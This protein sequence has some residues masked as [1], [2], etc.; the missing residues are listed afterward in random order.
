MWLRRSVVRTHSTVPFNFPAKFLFWSRPP[1]AG[2]RSCVVQRHS[3]ICRGAPVR[4]TAPRRLQHEMAFVGTL[5]PGECGKPKVC[6]KPGE[7]AVATRIG[8]DD[9]EPVVCSLKARRR[10]YLQVPID[11]L[12]MNPCCL[13]QDGLC[14]RYRSLQ[15]NFGFAP[16]APT[17]LLFKI[18][19]T[20]RSHLV[21]ISSTSI[22]RRSSWPLER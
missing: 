16:C 11:K 12:A 14:S 19:R 9:R 20:D 17:D 5:P 2:H 7:P 1:M 8:Y 13:S 3:L 15:V 22:R 6:H 18:E 4:S 21:K 10:G